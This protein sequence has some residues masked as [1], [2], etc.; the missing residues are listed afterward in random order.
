MTSVA[1]IMI[2]LDGLELSLTDL[3][4]CLGNRRHHLAALAVEARGLALQRCLSRQGHQS[5]L[6]KTV[7]AFEFTG[8][9]LM[10]SRFR[11]NLSVETRNLFAKLTDMALKS[12]LAL[13]RAAVTAV[14]QR[15]FRRPQ[16]PEIAVV[17]PAAISCGI[18]RLIQ[19]VAFR[20]QARQP[21]TCLIELLGQNL[22]IGAQLRLV[23]AQKQVT[24]V[25]MHSVANQNIRHHAARGMLNFLHIRFHHQ[26]A[27]HDNC[28]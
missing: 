3:G 14:K 13:R 27:R 17:R 18:C 6:E 7:H 28:A 2:D 22:G 4:F 25:H 9:Q 12:S 10:L 26:R 11:F 23:E 15:N 24:G 8:D 21:H 20:H 5:F 19:S 16:S 1:K